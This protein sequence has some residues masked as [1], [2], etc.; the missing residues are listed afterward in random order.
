MI[1]LSCRPQISGCNWFFFISQP[2]HMLLVLKRTVLMNSQ[3]RCLN[4][5]ISRGSQFYAEKN[6]ELTLWLWKITRKMG[7]ALYDMKKMVYGLTRETLLLIAHAQKPPRK[8][9]MLFRGLSISLWLYLHHYFMHAS[10]KGSDESAH[11]RNL[12]TAFFARQLIR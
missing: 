3:N 9:S 11:M 8:T 5:S 2:K 10:S 4:W 1:E 12:T 7:Y 6:P